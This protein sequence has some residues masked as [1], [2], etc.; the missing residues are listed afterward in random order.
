MAQVVDNLS[1]K[2]EAL[3][4]ALTTTKRRKRKKMRKLYVK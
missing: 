3:S 2:H 4:T 1:N